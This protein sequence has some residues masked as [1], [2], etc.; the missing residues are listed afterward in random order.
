MMNFSL[1]L[2]YKCNPFLISN[3]NIILNTFLKSVLSV[4][5]VGLK[6][7]SVAKQNLPVLFAKSDNCYLYNFL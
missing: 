3:Q 2:K 7:A 1:F 6:I 4:C 5:E